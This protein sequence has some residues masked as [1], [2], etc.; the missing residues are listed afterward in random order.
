MKSAILPLLV[1]LAGPLRAQT[2]KSFLDHK[3]EVTVMEEVVPE[4]GEKQGLRLHVKVTNKEHVIDYKNLK[5]HILVSG[6]Y[7]GPKKELTRS[8]E[9]MVLNHQETFNLDAGK[10]FAHSTPLMAS[11]RD[12]PEHVNYGV[13]YQGYVVVVLDPFDKIVGMDTN[14]T[15]FGERYRDVRETAEGTD[16]K[17]TVLV[18]R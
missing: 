16:Y 15:P 12:N 6:K 9:R 11:G 17:A 4:G 18:N 5:L 1:L 2:G 7:G 14:H 8:V 3:L 13:F 10:V